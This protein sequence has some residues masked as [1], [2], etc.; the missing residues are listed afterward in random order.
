MLNQYF[1]VNSVFS[2]AVKNLCN[3]SSGP[4]G[5]GGRAYL[6]GK[7]LKRT[8][9]NFCLN[10]RLASLLGLGASSGKSK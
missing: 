6:F 9:M 4:T 1:F 8:F 7:I 3:T 2:T 10:N 5:I